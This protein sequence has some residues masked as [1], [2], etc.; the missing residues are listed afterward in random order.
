[1]KAQVYSQRVSMLD[2]LKPH[3]TAGTEN[4]TA[5][6]SRRW[7]TCNMYAEIQMEL[8]MKCF[9]PNNSC[10][11]MLRKK[12]FQ[13]MNKNIT[14]TTLKSV[15]IPKLHVP[16]ISVLFLVDIISAILTQFI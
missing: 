9:A 8:A 6:S 14:N 7:T 13:L 3:A 5:S 15:F 4:V 2:E 11:C 10:T 16:Q 12:V 1:V